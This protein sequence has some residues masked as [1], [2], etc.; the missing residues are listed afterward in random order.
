MKNL[1]EK[2][3]EA[4]IVAVLSVN[5]KNDAVDL[6]KAL[7]DGGIK[8]IELTLRT[9]NALE[10]AAAIA[11]KAEGVMLGIGTVLTP[12]QARQA[13]S[14]GADFAVSPGC[15]VRVIDAALEAGLPF[16][17]GIMTP[18]EI[19]QSLEHGCNLMKFFPAGTTGGMKHLES[20][21]APYKHLGVS[22]I[23][24]G[25]LKLAN[26]GEYLS[27]PLVAAIGGSWIAPAD[28][29]KARDWSTIRKNAEDAMAG[30]K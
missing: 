23:P 8:A 19:E 25:G 28:L 26:M 20:M 14:V 21:A 12:E 22:F 2:I 11:E 16:A 3:R 15:N 9:P 30:I 17:P 10:C 24:L 4:R 27:S 18:S 13:K 1:A 29:I 6:A 7:V 5:D